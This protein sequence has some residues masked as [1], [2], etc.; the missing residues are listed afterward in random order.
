MD[1][2][3]AFLQLMLI[4]PQ[5]PIPQSLTSARL[6][7]QL[8]TLLL[9]GSLA[10][11]PWA[12]RQLYL[13]AESALTGPP[14]M[15]RTQMMMAITKVAGLM[16][17]SPSRFLTLT[18]TGRRMLLIRREA[19]VTGRLQLLDLWLPRLFGMHSLPLSPRRLRRPALLHLEPPL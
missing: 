12:E 8:Q 4:R 17:A 6:P 16:A 9:L 2:L 18:M 14:L 5:P 11:S 19:L 15:M 7:M 1:A 13:T 10:V 3:L